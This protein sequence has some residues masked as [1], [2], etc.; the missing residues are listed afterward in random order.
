LINALPDS[1]LASARDLLKRIQA[2]QPEIQFAGASSAITR[3]PGERPQHGSRS[4]S[5]TEDGALIRQ[6]R[7]LFHG[8]EIAMMERF[9]MSDDSKQLKYSQHLRGPKREHQIEI[10]FDLT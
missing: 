7:E 2:S 3:E 9:Q 10:D 5:R 8:H 6:T 1:V 4:T